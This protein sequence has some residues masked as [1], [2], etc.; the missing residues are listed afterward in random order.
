MFGANTFLRKQGLNALSRVQG[1]ESSLPSGPAQKRRFFQDGD[2]LIDNTEDF[3]QQQTREEFVRLRARIEEY[4]TVVLEAIAEASPLVTV[5]PAQADRVVCPGVVIRGKCERQVLN[6]SKDG[7]RKVLSLNE[8]G[9]LEADLGTSRIE[10]S[11]AGEEVFLSVH[12]T[13]ESRFFHQCA[14]G[15]VTVSVKSQ[16]EIA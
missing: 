7:R 3:A 6:L 13:F 15:Y 2:G 5:L 9:R 14:S 16:K 12:G 1:I 4:R 8:Q 10:F 11:Q